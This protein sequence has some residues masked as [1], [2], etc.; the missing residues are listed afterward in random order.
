ML[1]LKITK[2]GENFEEV[3]LVQFCAISESPMWILTDF[4]FILCL[5]YE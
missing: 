1:A 3:D 4:W 5:L 2:F